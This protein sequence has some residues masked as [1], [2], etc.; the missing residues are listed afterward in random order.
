MNWLLHSF[1]VDIFFYILFMSTFFPTF[2]LHFSTFVSTFFLHFLTVFSTFSQHFFYIFST[3][4]LHF[5]CIFSTFFLH[6]FCIFSALFSTFSQR[7]STFQVFYACR[8]NASCGQLSSFCCM[9]DKNCTQKLP[10]CK[11]LPR[12]TR[13]PFLLLTNFQAAQ[14]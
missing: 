10:R 4:F 12:E 8:K 13:S 2:S 11:F 5:F 3:F 14:F 1:E 9:V 7:F 6:F